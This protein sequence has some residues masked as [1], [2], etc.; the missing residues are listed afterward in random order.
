MTKQPNNLR[1]IRLSQTDKALSSGGKI[2]DIM[3]ITPQYYYDLETCRGGRKL[4]ADHI[5]KLTRIFNVTADEILGSA[6]CDSSLDI[7]KNQLTT[8]DEIIPIFDDPKVR[9][10]ARISF[11]KDPS[12]AVLLKKL[13]NSMLEED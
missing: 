3:G 13:I 8:Q 9:A 1:D 10:L 6:S 2:A 12:K 5:N 4:N 7:S 11:S